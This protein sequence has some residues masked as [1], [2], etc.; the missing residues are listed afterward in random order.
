M[1][2]SGAY[3]AIDWGTT[4]RRAY[5]MG[6]DGAVLDS[7]RTDRGV[8]AVAPGAFPLEVAAIREQMGQLPILA[9]GMIGS[10]RGWIDVPYV[11]A[12]AG[13]DALATGA[14]AAPAND[15]WIIPGV[16]FTD[17]DRCDVMRGEEIQVIGAV[18]AGLAPPDA[19]FCQ[20]GTHNKWIVCA[21]GKI[22]S[23][24]TALTGELFALLRD[25]GILAGMLNGPIADGP[26]FRKGVNRGARSC[27]LSVALFEVRAAVLLGEM[28]PEDA[29][30]FASGV[31]I[32]SDVG[33]RDDLAAA[34]VHLLGS[35][36]LAE[37]YES[38]IAICGG[39]TVRLDGNAAFAAG[40]HH[41]RELRS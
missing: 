28:K 22:L 38:A 19:Q 3:V 25:H 27:D 16:A 2:A 6:A 21:D 39:Q 15:M 1:P 13:A 40:I 29:A 14:V 32:G 17:G 24:A 4:N 20:P 18:Q 30:A 23:F 11:G 7:V 35:G 34:P 12:P 31:L 41:I 8:L 9:A 36:P 37:L 10:T 26:A 33:A 5:L